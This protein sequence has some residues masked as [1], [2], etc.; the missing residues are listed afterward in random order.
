MAGERRASAHHPGKL[1]GRKRHTGPCR[2]AGGGAA[3]LAP[4]GQP[5]RA[6]AVE[7]DRRTAAGE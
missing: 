2:R 6:R 1:S 3:E 4:G 7:C 5:D